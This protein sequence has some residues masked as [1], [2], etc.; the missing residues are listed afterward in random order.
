MVTGDNKIILPT[1]PGI[2]RDYSGL[3]MCSHSM[4]F[5]HAMV[6]RAASMRG[7]CAPKCLATSIAHGY[8]LDDKQHFF[9]AYRHAPN[10][11]VAIYADGLTLRLD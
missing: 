2:R 10:P 8:P 5:G 11:G 9:P 4:G 7:A 1:K 6:F 3:R